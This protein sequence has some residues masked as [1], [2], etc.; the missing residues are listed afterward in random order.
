MEFIEIIVL[1]NNFFYATLAKKQ[2]I[3]WNIYQMATENVPS[4]AY[5]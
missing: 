3:L 1:L 2:R 4:Q 5:L